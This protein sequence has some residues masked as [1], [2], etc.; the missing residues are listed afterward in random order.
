MKVAVVCRTEREAIDLVARL[1]MVAVAVPL[2]A[3]SSALL[4]HRFTCVLIRSMP[5]AGIRDTDWWETLLSRN[6]GPTYT[7]DAWGDTS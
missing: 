4:G 7:L 3:E 5:K 1:G 2:A 6:S